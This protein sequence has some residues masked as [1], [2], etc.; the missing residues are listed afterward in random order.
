VPTCLPR[1]LAH[2]PLRLQRKLLS[3]QQL[4][5]A[6]ICAHTLRIFLRDSFASS[7]HRGRRYA[8]PRSLATV[9]RVLH[10]APST[11]HQAPSGYLSTIARNLRTSSPN[12]H[13]TACL[14]STYRRG[15]TL[16]KNLRTCH[17]S[18]ID[19]ACTNTTPSCLGRWP[20]DAR[21]P[22]VCG[23]WHPLRLQVGTHEK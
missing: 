22:G 4:R 14:P 9:L 19:S 1:K 23:P 5:S 11:K 10:Q 15:G 18:T 16:A 7:R 20:A 17:L 3:K 13:L 21:D 12:I 6:H 2:L 8:L